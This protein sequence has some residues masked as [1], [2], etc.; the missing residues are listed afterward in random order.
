MAESITVPFQKLSVYQTRARV[1][2]VGHCKHRQTFSLLKASKQEPTKLVLIEDPRTYTVSEINVLLR[3][4][5][6]ANAHLG[7]LQ[8]VAHAHGIIGCFSFTET[9]YLLLITKKSFVGSI[10]GELR[11][12]VACSAAAVLRH[13]G[14]ACVHGG[15]HTGGAAL[16][17]QQRYGDS[18]RA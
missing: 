12:C 3:E 10:C 4:V 2:I 8:L 11:S 6:E 7:G 15:Q 17:Q 9:Y 5:H 13:P 1:F 16:E 14:T 18:M